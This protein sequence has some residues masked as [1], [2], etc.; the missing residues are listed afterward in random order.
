LSLIIWVLLVCLGG[1]GRS[2]DRGGGGGSTPA[3]KTLSPPSGGTLVFVEGG[4]FTMGDAEGREDETPHPV[5]LDSF[6]IDRT[7]VTQKRFEAVMGRNPSTNKGDDRP[8]ETVRWQEAAEFCNLASEKDGLTPCYDLDTGECNFEADGY[9]LP[10]EAEWE[11]ACRGGTTTAYFFGD[12]PDKIDAYGWYKYNAEGKPHTVAEKLPNPYKLFD[13]TGNVW[14]WCN[15]WYAADYYATSP[16]RNPR[17]PETGKQKVMRGGAYDSPS[18][19]CRS[20]FR[21]SDVPNFTDA[22]FGSDTYGFRRVRNAPTET[23]KTE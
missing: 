6:Y 18:R 7:P 19:R 17:G 20:A 2:E 11:Y 1:C 23:E 22:C 13:M 21:H 14:E 15:D 10:T 12:D 16:Q 4:S 5:T 3:P 8:V 9:R